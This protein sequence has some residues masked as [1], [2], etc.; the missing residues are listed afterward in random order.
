MTRIQPALKNAKLK[1]LVKACG[2]K[3]SRREIIELR[4]GRSKPHK[5]TRDLL[6]SILKEPAWSR[7]V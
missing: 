2:G 5:K 7:Y 4:A 3:P 6:I 1:D